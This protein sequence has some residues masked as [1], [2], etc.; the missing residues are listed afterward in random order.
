MNPGETIP[1]IIHQTWK[2]EDLLSFGAVAIESKESV[3]KFHPGWEYR[4]WT[5]EAISKFVDTEVRALGEVYVNAFHRLPLM[6]MKIDYVRYLWMYL[7]GGMYLDLDNVCYKSF[8]PSF[9]QKGAYFISRDWA[10][11]VSEFN[12]SVHQAWLASSARHPVW[13]DILNF[14]NSR[15]DIMGRDVLKYTGPNGVSLAIDT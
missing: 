9:S 8:S 2:S 14:I 13:I 6:I 1:K 3:Q 4:L 12:V 15:I 11:G 10:T 7:Y 5:D